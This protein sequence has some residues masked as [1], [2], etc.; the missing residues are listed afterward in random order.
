MWNVSKCSMPRFFFPQPVFV[1]DCHESSEWTPQ[2]GQLNSPAHVKVP[3]YIPKKADDTQQIKLPQQRKH[4]TPL[5]LPLIQS[6]Q[7]IFKV[8]LSEKSKVAMS[9]NISTG[10][11]LFHV[12]I[13]KCLQAYCQMTASEEETLLHQVISSR[14]VSRVPLKRIGRSLQ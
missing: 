1:L 5:H 11:N 4:G 8:M 12:I 6:S 7:K 14:M 2:Q 3:L 10:A 9:K 13:P